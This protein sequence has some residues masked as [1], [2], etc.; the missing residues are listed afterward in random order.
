MRRLP[1]NSRAPRPP[2]GY[3]ARATQA[4][5]R[6]SPAAYLLGC[7]VWLAMYML[8]V[9][10]DFFSQVEFKTSAFGAPNALLRTIKLALIGISLSV[11]I[12]KFAVA[13]MIMARLNR[14]FWLFLGF[15]LLSVTW[16][17]DP[18][19]TI[20]RF[21]TAMSSVLPALAFVL[22]GW[23]SSRFQRVVRPI[24]TVLLVGSLIVG[25]YSIDMVME[26]G[27]AFELKGA[28]HGMTYTKNSF[29]Q[30]SGLG[31]LFWFHALIARQSKPLVALLGLATAFTCVILS[32]SSTSLF[33]AMFACFFMFLLL[34]APPSMRK[35]MPYVVG[36]F[37]TVVLTYA[38]A[39]L[40][41]V[42]GLGIL[43]EPFVLISGKD[44]TFSNRVV[45]WAI[46]K[47]HIALSPF[48][49]SGYGAYWVGPFPT[50]PS[51]V[52]TYR[53]YVYPTESHNGYLEIINDLG[54]VGLALFLGF[55]IV[56]IRQ[57]LAIMKLDKAQATLFLGLLFHQITTNF[58]ES[59]WMVAASFCFYIVALATASQART[60]FDFRQA[61]P[62]S[63]R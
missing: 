3:A 56:Y 60:L 12:G 57:S 1:P 21:I 34:S 43:L 11:I 22:I 49:G 17:I 7:M 40:N 47:E 16:S 31:V 6:A 25:L 18:G 26:K 27:D 55:L 54:Y 13:K 35:K 15:A 61:I 20:N 46:I 29:G 58:S 14:F 63:R 2:R 50:S 42:P 51:F 23:H 62:S 44:M 28:W 41:I 30:L 36:G 19:A 37:A 4:G 33:S 10:P 53:M 8:A 5:G 48:I 39:A 9:P 24:I 32:R 38:V 59:T 45:I 52:F